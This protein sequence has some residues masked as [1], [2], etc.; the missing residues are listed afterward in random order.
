MTDSTPLEPTNAAEHDDPIVEAAH[1]ESATDAVVVDVVEP[2]EPAEAAE[3]VEPAEPAELSE[4][5]GPAE[6]AELAEP[7]EPA[8]P[9]ETVEQPVAASPALTAVRP[10]IPTPKMFANRQAPPTVSEFGRVG[11][12]GVVYLVTADGEREVGS[13]PG[14][15]P[16]DALAYFVR[17]YDDLAAAVN[18]LGQRVD[19]TDVPTKEIA[20]SLAALRPQIAD[21]RVVGDLAALETKLTDIEASLVERR[22]AES[23]ARAEAKAAATVAREAL[24]SEAEGISGQHEARIQWKSSGTRMRE[25][26]DLWK[27]HQ[28]TG[29]RLDK[30]IEAALWQRFSAARNSFDKARRS[31]FAQ[32]DSAHGEAKRAKEKLVAE[33]ERMSTSTDWA[34]TAGGF[35]RLM[36]EWRR[37]GRA[38]RTDDDA[39]WERFKSAQDAFFAAKDAV[40]AAEDESFR[41]NLAVKESLLTEAESLLPVRDLAAAKQALRVIQ[42]KW[43]AAGKVPRAD[44]ERTEKALRRVEQAVRDAEDRRW[45]AS[46]P[47]AAARAQSLVDQLEKAVATLEKDLAKAQDSGHD[48]RIREAQ[49][50]LD[51]RQAWLTQ[52]RSGLAEFGPR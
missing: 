34:V 17:K 6:P 13:Y 9:A 33:A 50:A 22:A 21:A 29:P 35:K 28:R 15:S 2:I 44:L 40:V 47:E 4:P 19:Q 42:D 16:G 25:L 37:A 14:V 38:S 18:L 27:E 46:N 32:L 41:A 43:E 52:A 49:A 30:D 5:A 39:L 3:P 8:E 11:D 1:T 10:A 45:A 51:A 24:V 20:E 48:K 7:A 36:D 12:D 26:L 31:H 23:A